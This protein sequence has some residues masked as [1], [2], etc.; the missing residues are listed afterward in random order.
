MDKEI[1]TEDEIESLIKK[2]IEKHIIKEKFYTIEGKIE[3]LK[4]AIWY[5]GREIDNLEKEKNNG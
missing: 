1:L 5:L 4:K 2:R 3:D